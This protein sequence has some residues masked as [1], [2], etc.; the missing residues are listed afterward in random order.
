MKDP[1]L[2]DKSFNGISDEIFDDVIKFFDFPL[3]DVEAN[4]AEEEDWDTQFKRI[5]EPAFD[6]FSVSSSDLYGK[7]QNRNPKLGRSFT[8]SVST[9]PLSYGLY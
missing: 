9:L 7:T 3:E 4:L 6:V 2:L 5:E 1:W 8:A